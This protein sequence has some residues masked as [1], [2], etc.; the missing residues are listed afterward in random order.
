MDIVKFD[1]E[2]VI[3]TITNGIVR[4]RGYEDV[5]RIFLS[6]LLLQNTTVMSI[7]MKKFWMM[8]MMMLMFTVRVTAS[9]AAVMIFVKRETLT[10]RYTCSVLI[11]IIRATSLVTI[12]KCNKNRYLFDLTK[13]PFQLTCMNFE[14]ISNFPQILNSKVVDV[15]LMEK[16]KAS[17]CLGYHYHKRSSPSH[18]DS[19]ELSFRNQLD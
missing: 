9:I 14:D 5:T 13:S 2:I 6:Y 4:R 3:I 19:L 1:Y 17:T 8:M 11:I 15:V 7:W 12:W 10:I 16:K 18:Q